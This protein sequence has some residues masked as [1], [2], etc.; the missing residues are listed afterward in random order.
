VV[1]IVRPFIFA[2]LDEK[3]F[4]MSECFH[5]TIGLNLHD[6]IVSVI[7]P[8]ELRACLVSLRYADTN[9]GIR[10]ETALLAYYLSSCYTWSTQGNN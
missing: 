3:R 1:V 10:L 6:T 4:G 2:C 8:F 5:I 7:A 9:I